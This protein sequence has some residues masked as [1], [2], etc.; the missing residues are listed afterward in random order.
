MRA[1][2]AIALLAG[3]VTEDGSS[4]DGIVAPLQGTWVGGLGRLDFDEERHTFTWNDGIDIRAGT[5]TL[6]TD[7]NEIDMACDRCILEAKTQIRVDAEHMLLRDVMAGS[8]RAR[9]G[10]S[11]I[12]RS[13]V[14]E[15]SCPG[16]FGLV[17][18]AIELGPATAEEYRG[19]CCAEAPECTTQLVDSG[20]WEVTADGFDMRNDA[21]S[22]RRFFLL[23]S[24]ISE[25]RWTR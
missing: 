21:G 10:A 22:H 13:T 12:G 4:P 1:M 16:G 19:S 15:E 20:P 7:E 8:N 6:N 23:L 2:I 24:G 11:W 17:I 14:R 3:C 25:G 9:A 18:H 5:W